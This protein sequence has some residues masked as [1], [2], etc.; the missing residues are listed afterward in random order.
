MWQCDLGVT[1]TSLGLDSQAFVSR[2]DD[3]L[4]FKQG[5]EENPGGSYLPQARTA[6]VDEGTKKKTAA[7]HIV[8]IKSRFFEVQ[9]MGEL[10]KISNTYMYRSFSG[11]FGKWSL[12]ILHH[13]CDVSKYG[14]G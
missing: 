6:G 10:K 11:G 4:L 12:A 13:Q 1:V 7:I 14:Y 3:F 8:L 9:W 5:A 2:L